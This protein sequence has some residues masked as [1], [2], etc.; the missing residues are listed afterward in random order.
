MYIS[1]KPVLRLSPGHARNRIVR[2][3]SAHIASDMCFMPHPRTGEIG[4]LCR[5]I[6]DHWAVHVLSKSAASGMRRKDWKD[7][8]VE[9]WKS[10][11]CRR[12]LFIISGNSKHVLD[13]MSRSSR[14]GPLNC[15]ETQYLGDSG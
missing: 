1:L 8:L 9:H 13:Y 7:V 3:H 14:P 10:Q 5:I 2:R 15:S 6:A 4:K 11:D 12:H